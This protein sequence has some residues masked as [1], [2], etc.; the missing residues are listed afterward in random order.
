ML[1]KDEKGT[2]AKLQCIY[3]NGLIKAYGDMP[4]GFAD[5]DFSDWYNGNNNS[6]SVQG[7]VEPPDIDDAELPSN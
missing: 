6:D 3:Y 2:K 1:G 7:Y 5:N 4:L